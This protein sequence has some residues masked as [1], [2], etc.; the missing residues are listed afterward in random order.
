MEEVLVKRDSCEYEESYPLIKE[1]NNYEIYLL[2]HKQKEE[3][4][5]RL[6]KYISVLNHDIKTPTIAQIRALEYLISDPK[7]ELSKDYKDLLI[8]TLESCKEQYNMINNLVTSIKYEKEEI[9]LN[10]TTYNIVS[11]IK[12]ELKDLQKEYTKHQNIINLH[13]AKSQLN[14]SGDQQKIKEALS[15]LLKQIIK[16]SSQNSIINIEITESEQKQNIIIKICE[17]LANTTQ[18]LSYGGKHPIYIEQKDYN[19]IGT[20]LELTLIKEVITSHNGQL[21]ESQSGKI[22]SIKIILPKKYIKY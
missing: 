14:I 17:I 11:L 6:D 18:T 21:I 16:E 19:S 7:L 15:R 8:L 2:K 20:K 4:K 10:I 1:T 22:K 5:K 12:D 3:F 9:D 13:T